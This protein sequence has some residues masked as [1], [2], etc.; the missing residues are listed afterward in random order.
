[1][2][3]NENDKVSMN[4]LSPDVLQALKSLITEEQFQQV[5]SALDLHRNNTQVHMSEEEKL[6][7][8]YVF[9]RIN[10][11][12]NQGLGETLEELSNLVINFQTHV[13]N[14]NIH[15]TSIEKLE[16]VNFLNSV[17]K[18]I[19]DMQDTISTFQNEA[20]SKFISTSEFSEL[21]NNLTDHENNAYVHI[22]T[23]ERTRWNNMLNDANKYA[24][25]ILSNH[26]QDTSLHS[27]SS[28]KEIW[29]NHVNSNAI[30]TTSAEKTRIQSHIDNEV[31]HMTVEEKTLLDG[32]NARFNE[33]T[34]AITSLR[35]SVNTHTTEISKLKD[36]VGI[37]T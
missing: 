21:S 33:L 24:D 14:S 18:A 29:N 10:E 16:Y 11:T 15:W 30:H 25:L 12:L 32:I 4:Q 20:N 7:L 35:N 19:T 27:T 36:A 9:N 28:E 22:Y 17:K 1:M 31:I 23:H 26:S 8:N 13:N 5:L 34:Q 2:D 3:W 6:K 37:L